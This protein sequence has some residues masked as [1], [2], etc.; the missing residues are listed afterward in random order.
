MSLTRARLL[1]I[2][3]GGAL[4]TSRNSLNLLPSGQRMKKTSKVKL[5]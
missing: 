5:T 1:I 2:Q 3:V 4:R